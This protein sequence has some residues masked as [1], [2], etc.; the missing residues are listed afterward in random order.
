MREWELGESV[1]REGGEGMWCAFA[2]G[3]FL[4]WVFVIFCYI[5]LC[6]VGDRCR[7]CSADPVSRNGFYLPLVLCRCP[8]S[9]LFSQCCSIFLNFMDNLRHFEISR[10]WIMIRKN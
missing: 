9:K 1:A 5:M 2:G 10:V 7:A 8:T 3:G 4:R 6:L